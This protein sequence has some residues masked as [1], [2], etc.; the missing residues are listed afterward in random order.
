MKTSYLS[1]EDVAAGKKAL[2]EIGERN[3]QRGRILELSSSAE[4]PPII[5]QEPAAP[6]PPRLQ[7]LG[8]TDFL[9][10]DI[11][12]REMLIG[13]ILPQ[14]GLVMLYGVRGTG[15]TMVA[16]GLCRGDRNRLP[17]MASAEATAR[18]AGRRRNACGGGGESV[19]AEVVLNLIERG[20]DADDS[21]KN[22][23]DPYEPP[24]DSGRRPPLVFPA[25]HSPTMAGFL[26]ACYKNVHQRCGRE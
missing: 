20:Q 24:W 14:K 25:S 26:S 22:T 23:A 15:K 8:V 7:P 5:L 13:P 17:E 6:E 1:P 9:K 3:R 21:G 16:L 11:K 19:S 4:S 12:P 10:L 18:L 2:A